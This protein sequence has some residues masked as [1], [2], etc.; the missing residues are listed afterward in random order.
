[1]MKYR[2]DCCI[3]AIAESRKVSWSPAVLISSLS[4]SSSCW[5]F[6]LDVTP[7][8]FHCG[9]GGHVAGSRRRREREQRRELELHPRR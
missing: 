5:M 4:R 9:D 8:P 1:M 2:S 3:V 7:I 6:V